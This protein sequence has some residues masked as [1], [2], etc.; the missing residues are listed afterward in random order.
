[1]EEKNKKT[2]EQQPP[3]SEMKRDKHACGCGEGG[4]GS[5]ACSSEENL[6]QEYLAGWKRC[7]AD[8]ENYKKRQ[9]ELQKDFANY[10][11]ESLLLQ[12]LPVIDNFHAS[13]EHIPEEQKN[14]PWVTGIMHIQKQLEAVLTTNGVAEIEVKIGDEFD[15]K[16]HDAVHREET[17]EDKKE[18][19]NKI[20]KIV[21]RGYKMGEKIIRPARVVVE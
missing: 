21:L 6:A 17:T 8:F 3:E 16:I 2:E 14:N 15:P 13:T 5:E 9:A 7:L 20:V 18:S 1:M 4:C 12:I 19:G 11:L 10:S